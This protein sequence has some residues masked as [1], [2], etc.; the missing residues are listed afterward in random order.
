MREKLSGNAAVVIL[1]ERDGGNPKHAAAVVF[2]SALFHLSVAS[3]L[4]LTCFGIQL[5]GTITLTLLVLIIMS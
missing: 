1:R 3:S 5:K 2:Y 4:S